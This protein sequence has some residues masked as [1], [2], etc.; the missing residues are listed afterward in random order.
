MRNA[1]RAM[2]HEFACH[3]HQQMRDIV[4]CVDVS[5]LNKSAIKM[6]L[7]RK[8][9][10]K[11]TSFKFIHKIFNLNLNWLT[12]SSSSSS[13][14]PWWL[15]TMQMKMTGTVDDGSHTLKHAARSLFMQRRIPNEAARLWF[16]VQSQDR[17]H[18]AQCTCLECRHQSFRVR[19]TWSRKILISLNDLHERCR[20]RTRAMHSR[21]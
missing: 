17:R 11:R 9:I 1:A 3:C 4:E 16:Y 21:N 6:N 13:S 12:S 5:H 15:M 14:S 8:I 20:W 19:V 2:S 18:T 10:M 7:Y